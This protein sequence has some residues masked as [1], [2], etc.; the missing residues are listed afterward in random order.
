MFPKETFSHLTMC[1][2][3][4]KLNVILLLQILLW[5]S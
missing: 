5:L 1:V 3:S 4:V 2:K